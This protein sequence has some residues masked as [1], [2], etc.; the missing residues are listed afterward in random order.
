[1]PSAKNF[2][3][4]CCDCE[5]SPPDYAIPQNSHRTMLASNP[6]PLAV[7][8]GYRFELFE[9]W[10]SNAKR[11]CYLFRHTKWRATGRTLRITSARSFLGRP[12]AISGINIIDRLKFSSRVNP[13]TL[14]AS[15]TFV[16]VRKFS[17]SLKSGFEG[18]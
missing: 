9:T 4:F 2:R 18:G 16:P 8:S 13:H 17:R 1:M 5:D 15:F 3:S 11:V 6:A 14:R 12:L 7:D 10:R